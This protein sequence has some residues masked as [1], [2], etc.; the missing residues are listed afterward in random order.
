MNSRAIKVLYI[1]ELA[2]DREKYS[3]CL[4]RARK[5]FLEPVPPPAS[6]DLSGITD[7]KIDLFL[8]DYQLSKGRRA[9]AR[10]NYQ[11][12]TLA[13]AIR[14][15]YPEH[16][17]VAL[18]RKDLFST[19]AFKETRLRDLFDSV[20]YKGDVVEDKSGWS[21]FLRGIGAGFRALRGTRVRT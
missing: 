21:D 5:I 1:D 9:D 11:G 2:G 18:T 4:S 13:T 3:D 6:L 14:E 8:I 16:P 17:V 20:I 19:G 10:V 15:R 12:G 7:G